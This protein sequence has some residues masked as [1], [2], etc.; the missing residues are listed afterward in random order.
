MNP[1]VPKVPSEDAIRTLVHETFNKR[2]CKWQ[3]DAAI[4]VLRGHH[5]M[6]CSRTGSGKTLSFWIPLVVAKA[7]GEK[8]LIIV[9]TPLNLLGKQGEKSLEDAGFS[10][11]AVSSLNSS[12]ATF[13]YLQN[14]EEGVYDVV[15]INPE[16]LMGDER[17]EKLWKNSAFI[18]RIITF[19][20]DEGHCISQWGK[21][22]KHYLRV[23]DLRI[24]SSLHKHFS[25]YHDR[26][27]AALREEWMVRSLLPP[28]K[29]PFS[30]GPH[31][32][33]FLKSRNAMVGSTEGLLLT[34]SGSVRLSLVR[35]YECP[36]MLSGVLLHVKDE[37]HLNRWS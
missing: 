2:A 12:N 16:I 1:R 18:S 6:T 15:I 33:L 4:A 22:R 5:V 11:I 19:I 3:I 21:F 17:M 37:G 7:R 30:P 8:K 36:T 35:D 31:T 34:S 27:I 14:I 23:G 28:L 9:V 26:R 20:F 32:S 25:Y 29:P 13:K 24:I 10:A